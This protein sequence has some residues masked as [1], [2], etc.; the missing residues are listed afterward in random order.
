MRLSMHLWGYACRY[1]H[2]GSISSTFYIRIFCTNVVSAAFS[3]YVLAL[4]RNLYKNLYVECWWNKL[5]L[6]RSKKNCLQLLTIYYLTSPPMN[7]L[8]VLISKKE[9]GTLPY[10]I[11]CTLFCRSRFIN[12][13]TFIPINCW[14]AILHGERI[15]RK[16]PVDIFSLNIFAIISI[17]LDRISFDRCMKNEELSKI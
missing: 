12:N 5:D 15:F 11:L 1:S 8:F 3:C 13:L 10:S 17:S 4:G 7:K 9:N 14:S 16:M 6:W 2:Q